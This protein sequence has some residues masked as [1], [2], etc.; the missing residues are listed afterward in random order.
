LPRPYQV[1]G[2]SFAEVVQFRC[3]TPPVIFELGDT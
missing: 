2:A 1:L 3:G